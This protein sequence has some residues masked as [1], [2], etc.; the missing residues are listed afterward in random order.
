MSTATSS[1]PTYFPSLS[2]P[3]PAPGPP[4]QCPASWLFP[5]CSSLSC[6]IARATWNLMNEISVLL[7]LWI[8]FNHQCP[9][10]GFAKTWHTIS[11]HEIELNLVPYVFC[12]RF[13]SKIV[14]MQSLI[15]NFPSNGPIWRIRAWYWFA[16]QTY[17]VQFVT[18][19]M[20]FFGELISRRLWNGGK[21]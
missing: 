15:L 19:R 1:P 20:E 18:E 9:G 5:L 4:V 3:D 14:F 11:T 7:N 13:Y 2:S 10:Q 8:I 6:Y 17:G 21:R 16:G 12:F